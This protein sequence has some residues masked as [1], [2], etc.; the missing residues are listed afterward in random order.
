MASRFYFHQVDT[1]ISASAKDPNWTLDQ[2]SIANQTLTLLPTSPG[3]VGFS[4]LSHAAGGAVPRYTLAAMYRYALPSGLSIVG[5]MRGE[6]VGGRTIVTTQVSGALAINIRD[7]AGSLRAKLIQH[8]PAP[9]NDYANAP[10]GTVFQLPPSTPIIDA[11]YITV[12]GDVLFVEIGLGWLVDTGVAGPIP[13]SKI[14]NPDWA[15]GTDGVA[16]ANPQVNNPWIEF[17]TTLAAAPPADDYLFTLSGGTSSRPSAPSKPGLQYFDTTT[18]I[19]SIWNG[20]A[21]KQMVSSLNAN[22]GAGVGGNITFSNTT[23]INV[24]NSGTSFTWTQNYAVHTGF[25][26]F[27]AT[28]GTAG[29]TSLASDAIFLYPDALQAVD[30]GLAGYLGQVFN[31]QDSGYGQ[32]LVSAGSGLAGTDRV[33]WLRGATTDAATP[34]GVGALGTVSTFGTTPNNN[35]QLNFSNLASAVPNATL[36]QAIFAQL[37]NSGTG[38]TRGIFL[39]VR[40]TGTNAVA[41]TAMD[42]SADGGST[43]AT[44]NITGAIVRVVATG[45]ATRTSMI[46]VNILPG[47]LTGTTTNL[48][49]TQFTSVTGGT[50]TN[51]FPF[52]VA[53]MTN[54]TTRIGY[55]CV[56]AATG[57]PTAVIGLDV[58]AHGVGTDRWGVRTANK[59]ENTVTDIIASTAGKGFIA[60]DTQG[61]ARFW[62]KYID[63]TGTVGVTVEVDENDFTFTAR[64]TTP[65]GSVLFKLDDVG[66]ALPTT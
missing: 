26:G 21:W 55:R 47:T 32:V 43:T 61:T 5:N 60:K 34:F 3:D 17:Q 20:A 40:N 48:I 62:R 35:I 41:N 24:A 49:G 1:G 10:Q 44:G 11:G 14:A 8:F 19:E 22:G 12:A 30:Q 63:A 9:T 58:T 45:A 33:L 7:A 15:A 66:T 54:G 52:N 2:R 50:L 29:T 6:L 28:A 51:L 39:T 37:L 4:Y 46:G 25:Y 18:N 36:Q 23:S 27:T 31:F 57:T 38:G 56:G 16:G 42:I 65:T 64:G 53:S 59:I 13:G